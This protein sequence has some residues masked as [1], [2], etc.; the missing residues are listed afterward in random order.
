M[1]TIITTIGFWFARIKSKIFK[2]HEILV[3]FY[4]KQGGASIG[5]NCLICTPVL[6]RESE[7]ISIGNN[8]TISTGVKFVTH[9]NSIKLVRPGKSDLFGRITIGNNCFIGENSIIMYGVVIPDNTIVA[10]GSVVTKSVS[11]SFKIIG[12]NP[13]KIIGDWDSYREKYKENAITRG[14]LHQRLRNDDSF[15]VKRN[16]M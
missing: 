5:T 1:N 8:V 4:R 2:K 13:A 7:L 12:G 9:D 14:E 15:L 16:I 6:T 10:A 11:E 3:D